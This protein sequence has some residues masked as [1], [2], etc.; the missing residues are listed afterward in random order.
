M[1]GDDMLQIIATTMDEVM[2]AEGKNFLAK[3]L[4]SVL[5]FPPVS[6]L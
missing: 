3:Y 4:K 5:A 2:Y 6:A 1:D